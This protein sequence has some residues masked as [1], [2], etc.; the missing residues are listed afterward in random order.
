MLYGGL[1]SWFISMICGQWSYLAYYYSGRQFQWNLIFEIRAVA[2][3]SECWGILDDCRILIEL[4]GI[5]YNSYIM[6]VACYGMNWVFAGYMA[7]SFPDF[8]SMI[9]Y[10]SMS[11]WVFLF[12]W[13]LLFPNLLSWCHWRESPFSSFNFSSWRFRCLFCGTCSFQWP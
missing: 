12:S 7:F 10:F 2:S 5:F 13:P 9:F 8:L 1:S 6:L 3:W 4:H 11:F